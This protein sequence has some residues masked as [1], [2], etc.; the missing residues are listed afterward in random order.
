MYL[1]TYALSGNK[2]GENMDKDLKRLLKE[3]DRQGFDVRTS[4]KGYPLIYRDGAFVTKLAQTPSDWRSWK[5]GIAALRRA[6]FRWP[7]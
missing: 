1:V 7:P 6:G 5:N 2:G 4:G 3:L